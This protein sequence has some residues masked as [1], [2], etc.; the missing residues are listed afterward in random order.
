MTNTTGASPDPGGQ[1]PFISVAARS[2][3]ATRSPAIVSWVIEHRSPHETSAATR[4]CPGH[5]IGRRRRAADH[6]AASASRSDGAA[7]CRRRSHHRPPSSDWLTLINFVDR[8]GHGIGGTDMR[9]GR[10]HDRLG[11]LPRASPLRR[12]SSS[13]L[14]PWSLEDQ[15]PLRSHT[16][17]PI[18]MSEMDTPF[19]GRWRS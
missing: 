7:G 13:R 6:R 11:H 19:D 15:V 9:A 18:R 3:D 12:R 17:R 8:P 10:D 5:S 2:P 16:M 14:R 4:V 1:H